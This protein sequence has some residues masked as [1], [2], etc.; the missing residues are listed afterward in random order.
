MTAAQYPT[1]VEQQTPELLALVSALGGQPPPCVAEPEQWYA[2]DP[3]PA[4]ER[5]RQCHAEPECAAY[6]V[7]L[8]ERWGVWGAIDRERRQQRRTHPP[9]ERAC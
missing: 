7:A 5:C 3:A 6:A 9:R 8:G 1:P 2:V 4:I